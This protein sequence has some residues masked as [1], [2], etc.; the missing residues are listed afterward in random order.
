MISQ[1]ATL[2]FEINPRG[3]VEMESKEQMRKH[4]VRSPDRAEA[5]M[6]CFADRTPAFIRFTEGTVMHEQAVQKGDRDGGFIPDEFSAQELEDAYNEIR[7]RAEGG[8]G[9]KCPTCGEP[10]GP[11]KTMDSDGRYYH[12]ECVKRWGQK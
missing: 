7:D 10:L 8:G 3:Q 11:T 1:L 4:G 6:L 12:P 9:G 5:L 2:R